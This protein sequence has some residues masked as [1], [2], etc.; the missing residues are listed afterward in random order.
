MPS[1]PTRSRL[2]R[3]LQELALILVGL[4]VLSTAVDW[5]RRPSQPASAAA[6]TMHDLQQQPLSLA[7]LSRETPV[8]LYF[9]GS[10]CGICR[11]TSPAIDRL[12]ADGVP[13]V[14][15]ALQS[16]DDATVAAYLAQHG[17]RFRTVNDADGHIAQQW[18][19][20]VTPTIVLLQDGRIRHHTSGLS[21]YWGLKARWWWAA[22]F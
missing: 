12:A 7:E 6:L 10:W 19:V 20:T 22:R 14:S 1:T 11:H 18:A 13:V 17:Y 8:L 5:W 15:I 2:R 16:G 4:M 3:H 9:W 21:S